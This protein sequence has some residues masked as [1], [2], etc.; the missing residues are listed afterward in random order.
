MIRQG[1]ADNEV[2]QK[3]INSQSNNDLEVDFKVYLIK[4]QKAQINAIAFIVFSVLYCAQVNLADPA[5]LSNPSPL[6]PRN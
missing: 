1:E 3:R 5:S 6:R 4:N 2:L